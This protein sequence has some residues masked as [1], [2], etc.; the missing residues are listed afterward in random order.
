MYNMSGSKRICDGFV[1]PSTENVGSWAVD[2]ENARTV[3]LFAVRAERRTEMGKF[4]ICC[5]HCGSVN[6]ASTGLFAKKKITCGKCGETIDTVHSRMATHTCAKCGTSFQYDQSDAV[7]TCPVC[8]TKENRQDAVSKYIQLRCPQCACMIDVGKESNKCFC[9]ICDYEMDVRKEIAKQ[10]LVGSG[11]LSNVEYRIQ[12]NNVLAIK[13]PVEDFNLGSQLLVHESQSAIFVSNGQALDEFGPGPHMLKTENLPLLRNQ[14]SIMDNGKNTPFRSEIYFFNQ[15]VRSGIKWGTDQLISFVLPSLNG[16]P[17]KLGMHGTMA[18]QLTEPRRL[19]VKLLG[20][21]TEMRWDDPDL[22]ALHTAWLKS[23]LMSVV[24]AVFRAGDADIFDSSFTARV[25][26]AIR[27]PLEESFARYGIAVAE[28]NLEGI[29]YPEDNEAYQKLLELRQAELNKTLERNR[30]EIAEEEAR[31][32][33]MEARGN[34][35]D[36]FIEA[37]VMRAQGYTGKDRLDAEVQKEFARGMGQWGSNGGGSGGGV[38]SEVVG[39]MLGMKMAGGMLGNF[40]GMNGMFGGAQGAQPTAPQGA[41]AG[42]WTCSCGQSGNTGRFCAG[43]GQPKP[44]AWTCSCG[45]SGNTGR[46]CAGC[47]QPKPEA[48][49]CSC[50][51]TGNTGRFCAGCGQPRAAGAWTCPQCGKTGNTGRCCPDCGAQKPN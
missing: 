18:L 16:L 19:L 6:T 32:K 34:R 44:E 28:F 9:P 22:T 46:F 14:L 25:S 35:A 29:Y 36:D 21:K 37:E 7:I 2:G 33:L 38:A 24:P 5:P 1:E 20:T 13:A 43:C 12:D 27:R 51:Q 26:D 39:T 15:T 42:S 4:A 3:R 31:R 23:Q 49:T 47:G 10:K 30:T 11:T 8:H 45:Q 40:G 48:W 17:M 50:G 41:A